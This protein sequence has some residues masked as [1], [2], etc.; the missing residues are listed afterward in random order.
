[1]DLEDKDKKLG[2]I[3]LEGGRCWKKNIKGK[4]GKNSK[5]GKNKDS[6]IECMRIFRETIGKL[7]SNAE[8]TIFRKCLI[9]K[10]IKLGLMTKE[11]LVLDHTDTPTKLDWR[12]NQT[13]TTHKTTHLVTNPR[14][15]V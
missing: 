4:L 11:E 14:E 8:Y 12:H 10:V 15:N 9:V 1:M 2:W 3:L 7:A 6:M 5:G 13:I